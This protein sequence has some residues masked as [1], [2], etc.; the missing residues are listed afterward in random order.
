MAVASATSIRVW[1]KGI[2]CRKAMEPPTPRTKPPAAMARGA[3]PG[4][5]A[6][7][8]TPMPARPRPLRK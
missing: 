8:A 3:S 7:A 1:K 5:A 6:S 2:I 4:G